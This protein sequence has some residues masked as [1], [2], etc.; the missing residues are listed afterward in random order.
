[1]ISFDEAIRL[2][3]AIARPLGTD[4]IPLSE[5]SGAILAEPVRARIDAPRTD[6]SA[7]DGYAL[8]ESDL[9]TLP[10]RLRMV[11]KSFAGA[12]WSGTVSPGECA[13]IF[14]GAPVPQG[15]DRVVMQE[16]IQRDG[17]FACVARHPGD[18]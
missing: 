9:E 6:V 5:A 16:G 2:I 14:T 3:S 11:G 12:G 17:E 4:R 7:M 10:A 8:R 1:M 18:A 15:C 13:R